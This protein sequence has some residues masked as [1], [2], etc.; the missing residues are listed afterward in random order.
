MKQQ[1]KAKSVASNSDLERLER[2]LLRLADKIPDYPYEL[3]LACRLSS[4]LEK[5]MGETA[6]DALRP[7]E[8]NYVLYQALVIISGGDNGSIAPSDIAQLTGE[9]PTN[10]T[11]ICNEL[12]KR[13]YITRSYGV[14]LDKR[15]IHIAVT[16]AGER[17][18]RK[19]QPLIWAKW[20]ARFDAFSP[21]EIKSVVTRLRRQIDNLDRSNGKS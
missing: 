13:H 12:E 6:N 8:L 4:Q 9:R 20:R 15:R 11:H 21:P 7:L 10:V 5:R 1:K 19:A 17:L 14:E 18:L 16:A 3:A 2:L